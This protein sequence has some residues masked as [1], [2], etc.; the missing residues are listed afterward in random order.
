MVKRDKTALLR[1]ETSHTTVKRQLKPL[2]AGYPPQLPTVIG[3]YF[4]AKVKLHKTRN[5]VLFSIDL[6]TTFFQGTFLNPQKKE[7]SQ[8][9]D[10]MDFQFNSF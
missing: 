10:C 2:A 5:M 3:C 1:R 4:P 8:T 9:K 6:S 7:A